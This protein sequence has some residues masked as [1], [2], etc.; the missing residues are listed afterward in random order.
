LSIED[1]AERADVWSEAIRKIVKAIVAAGVA[2]AAAIGGLLMWWPFGVEE[3]V[4]E[5]PPALIA[6]TGFGAQCSQLYSAI[7]HTWTEG[8]WAVWERL[9]KD[10]GC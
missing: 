5:E 10:M 8:Q 3:V 7:D 6:G 2:L 4:V 1:V 9:K